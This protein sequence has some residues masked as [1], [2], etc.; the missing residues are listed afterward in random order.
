MCG[1]FALNDYKELKTR[2]KLENTPLF[3]PS[4]NISPSQNSP[5]IIRQSPNSSKLM[6][7]GLIPFWAKNPNIGFKM[8]NARA[9]TV[10]TTAS[11]RMP[12]KKQR[13]LVPA[14]GFYEW[15]KIG[16]TKEPHYIKRNDNKLFSM[17][18]L[19]DIWKDAEGHETWSYTIIT[20][21]P[22]DL[23]KP[24]HNRMPVILHAKDEETWL[25]HSSDSSKLLELLKPYN[26]GMLTEYIVSTAV[27]SPRS[28]EP[29][30]IEPLKDQ[31]SLF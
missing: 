20:T 9:E 8:I 24:I 26:E 2:F 13:C 22:N 21:E 18:G 28:N 23:M 15:K 19:F 4:Y 31:K 29:G 16:K 5:V 25:D 11:Y 3:S 10:A 27:N 30:L 1:R 6:K 17:A 14:N 12:F 7:W